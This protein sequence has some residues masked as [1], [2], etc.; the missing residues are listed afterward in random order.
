MTFGSWL[1]EIL[2]LDPDVRSIVVHVGCLFDAGK[3]MKKAFD[4]TKKSSVKS[5]LND[6][7]ATK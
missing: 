4:M 1:V 2:L 7:G 5:L 3:L 6:Y